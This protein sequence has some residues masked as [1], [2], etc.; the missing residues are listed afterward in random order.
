MTTRQKIELRQSEIRARLGEIAAL[1]G[2]ARTEEIATEQVTLMTELRST[3]PRLQAAIAAEEQD[4]RFRGVQ[5]TGDGENRERLELRGRARLLE[6]L[7]A[8]QRGRHVQGAE[9]EL[10]EAAGVDGIPIELW[11]VP[12][13][14]E[15]RDVTGPPGTVGVNLDPIRPAVFARSI[16]ARLGID[17]PRVLSGTYAT[18]TISTSTA[19][20]AK[21]K[22]ADAP[23]TA[24]MFTVATATP[25]RRKRPAGTDP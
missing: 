13:V 12:R 5:R 10:R 7:T 24:G 4:D 3:E 1:E 11:D 17:M 14:G 8:A 19:A 2:E 9:A 22:S 16:A 23:A 20:A 18:A 6:Y 25:K 15:Q 21:A